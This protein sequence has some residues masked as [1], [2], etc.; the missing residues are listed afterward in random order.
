MALKKLGKVVGHGI[1]TRT[2]VLGYAM[3]N[4]FPQGVDFGLS[5][6]PPLLK[7]AK[8]PA[9]SLDTSLE[10]GSSIAESSLAVTN[11]LARLSIAVLNE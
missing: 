3:R 7:V 6:S 1:P 8:V 4:G 2:A 9:T 10:S 11:G 5:V